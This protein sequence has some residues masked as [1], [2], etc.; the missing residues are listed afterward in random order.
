[1]RRGK[2][3]PN[4]LRGAKIISGLVKYRLA[5]SPSF[6][7]FINHLLERVIYD[8]AKEHIDGNE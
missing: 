5:F 4:E 8:V 2:K 1:M 3:D 7:T 6:H